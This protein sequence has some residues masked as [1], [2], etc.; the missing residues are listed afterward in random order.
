[1]AR[2]V[3]DCDCCLP[4]PSPLI[5]QKLIWAFN[6]EPGELLLFLHVADDRGSSDLRVQSDDRKEAYPSS[7]VSSLRAVRSRNSLFWMGTLLHS[8]IGTDTYSNDILAQGDRM[9]RC[10][11]GSRDA[12][13]RGYYR[14]RNGSIQ[15]TKSAQ[16]P[17]RSEFA[18]FFFRYY[19]VLDPLCAGDLFP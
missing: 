16:N 7:T 3:G 19:C 15:P 11:S 4:E 1:M 9:V 17:S 6:D 18:G 2:S 5:E 10:G 14:N 13:C 12:R 8:S